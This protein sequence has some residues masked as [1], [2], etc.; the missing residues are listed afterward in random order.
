MGPHLCPHQNPSAITVANP[1]V[2]LHLCVFDMLFYERHLCDFDRSG[3]KRKEPRRNPIDFKSE[4]II[5]C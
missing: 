3:N 1:F 5:Y 4:I 2:W